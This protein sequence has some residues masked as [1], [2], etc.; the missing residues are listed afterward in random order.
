[1]AGVGFLDETAALLERTP[2]ILEDLLTG[3]P[4]G[5]LGEPDAPGGWTARDVVGH[6][7]SGEV[8]NWIPRTERLLADGTARP[9]DPFD[10]VAHEQRDAGLS[11]EELVG[12]FGELRRRNL[13][14]LRELVRSEADLD[15]RGLHPQLGEVTLRQLLAAWSTHDLDHV[16]QVY[17][18]LAGS[19]DAAVGPYK[20]FLG[21]LTRRD[22]P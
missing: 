10:R 15:R 14:R 5:W 18:S 8:A 9:F 4:E 1:M 13:D 12:R 11:L 6:L 17:A 16:Q 20:E 3:L 7:I 19:R 21:I 2:V 22:Q